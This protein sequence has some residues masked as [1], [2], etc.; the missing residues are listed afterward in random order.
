[1]NAKKDLL[2]QKPVQEWTI[3]DKL[4]YCQEFINNVCNMKEVE[5]G[6]LIQSLKQLLGS[7]SQSS[8]HP[9]FAKS[10]NV[11]SDSLLIID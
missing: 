1:M 5:R 4:A 2:S 7:E 11:S 9:D 3:Q 8:T 10:V 6:N